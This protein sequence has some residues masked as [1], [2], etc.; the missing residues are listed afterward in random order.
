MNLNPINW[1]KKKEQGPDIDFRDTVGCY[2]ET[3]PPKLAK[4]V[5]VFFKEHQKKEF[6]S[7]VMPGCPGMWDYS[8]YGYIITS[9]ETIKIKANK[10]G[11]VAVIKRRT[12]PPANCAPMDHNFVSGMV[13]FNGIPPNAWKFD[14]PWRVICKK[15]ISAILMPAFYHAKYLEDVYVV[16]G[17]V[18]YKDYWTINFIFS[19]RRTCQITINAGE[20][21]LH[22]LP[23][24]N[25]PIKA[26]YGLIEIEQM[27]DT[28]SN[29]FDSVSQFYR[30]TYNQKKVFHLGKSDGSEE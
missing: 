27:A 20:P 1:F 24:W 29:G 7:F 9:P 21:L 19:I 30:K 23:Y 11:T 6:G 14:L 22:V 26:N 4:D 16:P 17:I 12:G 13:E 18:D 10:A 5:P 3:F 8:Q 25:K 15:N 28:L 2:F